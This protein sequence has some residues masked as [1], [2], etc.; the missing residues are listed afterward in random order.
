MASKRDI[1]INCNKERAIH[2]KGL[3][4]S[5][6]RKQKEKRICVNCKELKC[7]EGRGL[8]EKCRATLKQQNKLNNYNL[9]DTYENIYIIQ[10]NV[11]YLK[12]RN[13]KNEVYY[14]CFN[15][16]HLNLIKQYKWY[17]NDNGY[18]LSASLKTSQGKDIRLARLITNV[19]DNTIV[20]D[21]GEDYIDNGIIIPKERNNLDINLRITTQLKNCWNTK[22]SRNNKSGF[23]GVYL[24]KT[25]KTWTAILKCNKENVLNKTFKEKKDAIIARLFAELKYF[26]EEF[27][28]QRHL[29]EEYGIT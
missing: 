6:Y 29:F 23:I 20:V 18:V 19:T 8:C 22:I 4:T 21:H 26:G 24:N 9:N 27:A 10:G 2:A 1:C 11:V 16:W 14:T 17:V 5:C 15:I 13:T 25:S 3:C 12:I 28:P 7:I